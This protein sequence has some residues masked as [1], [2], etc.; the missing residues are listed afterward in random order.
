MDIPGF[1][2][3]S[4]LMP[5]ENAIVYVPFYMPETHPKFKDSDNIFKQKVKNYLKIANIT[6]SD[7][8]FL[9]IHVSRY[10]Y[11]QPV[12]NINFLK[13]IPPIDCGIAEGC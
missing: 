11:S 1:V 9:D 2:E 4:N 13:N 3:Y 8:D 10:F 12:C 7:K 6:L 5:M